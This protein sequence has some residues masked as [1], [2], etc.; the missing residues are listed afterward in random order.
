M[1]HPAVFHFSTPFCPGSASS[2]EDVALYANRLTAWLQ[3]P[4]NLPSSTPIP[5]L[6][7]RASSAFITRVLRISHALL[8]ESGRT[9]VV[10]AHF[11][12]EEAVHDRE[13]ADEND[14]EVQFHQ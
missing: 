7:N 11:S 12:E 3:R 10:P 5:G 6:R 8:P 2:C 4:S 1:K 14:A 9:A 13:L